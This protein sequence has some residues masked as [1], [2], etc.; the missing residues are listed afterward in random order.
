[1]EKEIILENRIKPHKIYADKAISVGTFLGGPLVGG[2]LAA[3]NFRAFGERAKIWRTW[4][5]AVIATIMLFGG[6]FFIPQLVKIPNMV[7][8]V[9]IAWIT[10]FL[11]RYAQGEKIDTHIRTGGKIYSWWRVVGISLLGAIITITLLFGVAVFERDFSGK[12][13]NKAYENQRQ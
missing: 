12:A 2:F 13:A 5:F 8:P 7:F 1:M 3:E 6:A 4:A 9:I 11:V 10:F